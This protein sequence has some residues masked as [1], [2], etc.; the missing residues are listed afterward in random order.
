MSGNW[1]SGKRLVFLTE[2]LAELAQTRALTIHLGNPVD[3]LSDTK[4]AT[5]Y[6]PVPGWR[7]RANA[8]KPAVVHPWP[9]L[10]VPGAE[11]IASFSAW[12]KR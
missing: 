4:L 7:T 12:N 11:S 8:I 2:R 10:R 6:A 9:W 3:I 5:T 1:L